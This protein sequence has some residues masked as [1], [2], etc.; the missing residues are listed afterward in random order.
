MLGYHWLAAERLPGEC[1]KTA[2]S[3]LLAPVPHCFTMAQ[4]Q[5]RAKFANQLLQDFGA[6]VHS[7]S[8]PLL[9]TVCMDCQRKS[10]ICDRNTTSEISINSE[11]SWRNRPDMA[12]DCYF[13]E[14]DSE[15]CAEESGGRAGV[16]AGNHHRSGQE[17]E[18]ADMICW[19]DWRGNSSKRGK[20]GKGEV[21][22]ETEQEGEGPCNRTQ[23]PVFHRQTFARP[24]M[25]HPPSMF[26][27]D[28]RV[29]FVRSLQ[30]VRVF[31]GCEASV[32]TDIEFHP[33]MG[34]QGV[35]PVRSWAA[36]ISP[37][38]TSSPYFS[39]IFTFCMIKG[40]T[41]DLSIE[42]QKALTVAIINGSTSRDAVI[43]AGTVVAALEICMHKY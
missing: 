28:L 8:A 22:P 42:S 38:V 34:G 3:S 40:G 24:I 21:P 27:S 41:I 30:D 13:S 5:I 15:D 19:E 29:Y 25:L 12:A 4:Q 36:A 18:P 14:S 17:N 2:S 11:D 32:K 16:A 9:S 6:G 35:T 37:I 20:T 7:T 26:D 31:A 43:F 33:F 1:L 10:C 39:E 23:T